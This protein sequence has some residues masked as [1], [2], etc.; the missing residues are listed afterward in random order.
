MNDDALNA[1]DG[2]NNNNTAS[3][4]PSTSPSSSSGSVDVL[5]TGSD[6][7]GA[8]LITHKKKH[9]FSKVKKDSAAEA[10]GLIH[11]GQRLLKID[12][13]SIDTISKKDRN[14]ML[15][16]ALAAGRV[17]LTVQD[18]PD[19]FAAAL[20]S[21]EAA[22]T[23]KATATAADGDGEGD[24]DEA[25]K[26]PPAAVTAVATQSAPAVGET[27]AAGEPQQRPR[28]DSNPILYTK[29][30]KRGGSV[31]EASES[32]PSAAAAPTP[33]AKAA[34]GGGDDDDGEDVKY[35]EVRRNSNAS[36]EAKAAAA[37]AAA[38]ADKKKDSVKKT[39]TESVKKKGSD[40]SPPA[41]R[42]A[43]T[44]DDDEE[45]VD[46]GPSEYEDPSLASSYA[47]SAKTSPAGLYDEPGKKGQ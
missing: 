26:A 40:P 24:G 18:D 46:A 3:D 2:D 38:K 8:V 16:S 22:K 35:A 33:A 4:E 37:K 41:S 14:T 29:V 13:Q 27:H 28:A 20:E 17:L 7:L 42:S 32:E 21:Q 11:A 34:G 5:I 19:G 31:D 43:S 44:H 36:K 6:K 1:I 12:G 23:K 47:D 9:Y 45:A 39:K 10:T 15:Q 25:S 30:M